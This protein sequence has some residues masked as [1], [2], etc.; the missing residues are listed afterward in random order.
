M[1]TYKLE[2]EDFFIGYD[3]YKNLIASEYK[4]ELEIFFDKFTYHRKLFKIFKEESDK[5]L[6]SDFNTFNFIKTDE[7]GLSSIVAVFLDIKGIHGQGSL[8]LDIFI[9]CFGN[10]KLKDLKNRDFKVYKEYSANG[11]RRIDILLKNND[12]A[13]IIEN[14]P[15]AGDQKDQITDYIEYME[16]E[17]QP[18]YK[19]KLFTIY[20]NKT[21]SEP[22][23]FSNSKL[24]LL[25]EKQA[26]N[27]FKIITYDMFAK[28]Y[29]KKCYEK[30]ES[31]KFRFFIADFI[32]FI[33]KKPNF[34][35]GED[36]QNG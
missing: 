27:E 28:I 5:K 16:E 8:F 36:G 29:L 20:L 12:F 11:N 3:K 32:E 35:N 26:N 33:D 25:K 10:Q 19:N 2:L 31:E 22:G 17:H 30:C 34:I 1:E 18:N 6:S 13:I 4:F 21:K 7:L 14:K 23:N 24:K 15:Y 9:S